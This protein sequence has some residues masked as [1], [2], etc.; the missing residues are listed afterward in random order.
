M[1]LMMIFESIIAYSAHD[2]REFF[3]TGIVLQAWNALRWSRHCRRSNG[4]WFC[5]KLVRMEVLSAPELRRSR[6]VRVDCC[7]HKGVLL[8]EFYTNICYAVVGAFRGAKYV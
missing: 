4:A 8:I 2:G 6:C 7:G 3:V 1:F 5:A